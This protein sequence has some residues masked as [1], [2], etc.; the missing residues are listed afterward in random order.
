MQNQQLFLT[1]IFLLTASIQPTLGMENTN[2]TPDETC[3]VE[4]HKPYTII[5]K[6]LPHYVRSLKVAE[7]NIVGILAKDD[8]LILNTTTKELILKEEQKHN[9][10]KY[11]ESEAFFD[12]ID[13]NKE[14]TEFLIKNKPLYIDI[15]FSK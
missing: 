7:N 1:L 4:Y 6:D 9:N 3:M 5:K 10:A 14:K 15:P 11:N 13:L 12:S 2:K 8:F